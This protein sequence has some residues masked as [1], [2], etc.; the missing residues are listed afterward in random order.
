MRVFGFDQE[1][2]QD[3]AT[4]S[5]PFEV[6]FS[7]STFFLNTSTICDNKVLK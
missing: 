7:P 5:D 3:I 1:K 4:A 6:T 2:H